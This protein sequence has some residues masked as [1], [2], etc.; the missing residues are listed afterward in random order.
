VKVHPPNDPDNRYALRPVRCY[1]QPLFPLAIVPFLN[2]MIQNWKMFPKMHAKI[3]FLN[4]GL[5][6]LNNSSLRPMA[7]HRFGSKAACRL[8][9]DEQFFINRIGCISNNKNRCVIQLCWTTQPVGRFC[10]PE[11]LILA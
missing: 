7:R 3:F 10:L 9:R 8:R 2:L 4:I 1:R 11:Q 5:N 6:Y